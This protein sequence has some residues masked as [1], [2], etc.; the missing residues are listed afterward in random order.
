MKNPW[1]LSEDELRTRKA[2]HTAVEV[3]Q[4]PQAW[5]ETL[6]VFEK[7]K[8]EIEAF[9]APL[10]EKQNLRIVFT[11]AGTS[12]Y[13]GDAIAPYLRKKLGLR[14]E[15]VATTDIVSNPLEYLEAKTPTVLV[16]FA[17]SG[18]SPES[19]AAYDL[20]E[21]LVKEIYQIVITCNKD[22][23]LA[24]RARHAEQK[25]A[26]LILNPPQTNDLGFAMTSSF[27]SMMIGGLLVFDMEKFHENAA[28]VRK[29]AD[30]GERILAENHGLSDLAASDAERFVF[31][32]SGG[33][34][35]FAQETCLKFLELTSGKIVAV[36]ESTMG[37]RH[38]P[39]S[40]INDRTVVVE[41]ISNDPYTRQYDLDLLRELKNDGG[42]FKVIAV[43]SAKD[44]EIASLADQLLVVD[45]AA[46][47]PWGN[48]AYMALGYVLFD[49]IL[50]VAASMAQQ[51]TPDNPRPDGTVNRVVKGV[52]IHPLE[53]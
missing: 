41:F 43:A 37:F 16:S 28:L 46:A 47:S 40:I 50:A 48:D 39:K 38:G 2:Y 30:C 11:G 52:T 36:S 53:K 17:R 18:N 8:A 10:L 44:Q 20:A 22:G 24:G 6:E 1:N 26:L 34:G 12:D 7:Q 49:H 25:N 33:L 21:Q 51:V 4:Q 19:V 13:V 23:K 5:R 14:V 31:L 32:G 35:G 9:V 3:C 27:T 45:P 15:G 29:I 42:K